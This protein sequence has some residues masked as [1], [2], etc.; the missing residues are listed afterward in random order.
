MLH[1]SH[2]RYD[3]GVRNE[4][5][6]I[7]DIFVTSWTRFAALAAVIAVAV[8]APTAAGS[9][10][11]PLPACRAGSTQP[12]GGQRRAWVVVPDGRVVARAA[13]HGAVVARF[14]P[15][16]AN[17]YPTLF[18]VRARVVDARCR[19][20]WYLVQLP[21][22]PNGATGFI[23]A[24]GAWVTTVSTRIDVD[25]SAR[26]LRL[27]RDGRVNL[28]TSV[29]IGK[30]GTPTP[31]GRF[32]VNQ[33][34]VPAEPTGPFG[35]GALGISAFSPTL[36]DWAQGGPIAIHGT[37]EPALIGRAVSNGCIRVRNATFRRLFDGVPAGTPVTIHP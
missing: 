6:Q 17:D 26:R 21:V 13:P 23:A 24:R 28:I 9:R 1:D 11:D 36:K 12:V 5:S 37:N 10:L 14:D 19:A 33:R 29:A 15:L 20:A 8:I 35:P 34:L 27:F 25:L 7:C 30:G 32:Y 3:V 18:S 31:V 16:N 2:D 4:L 22:R